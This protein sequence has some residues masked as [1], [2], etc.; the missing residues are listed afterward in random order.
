MLRIVLLGFFF[1]LALCFVFSSRATGLHF[2]IP[3]RAKD[4]IVN[5]YVW[6]VLKFPV[7][8]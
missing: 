1:C 3:N 7:S 4:E 2:P 8:Y 6:G 5:F